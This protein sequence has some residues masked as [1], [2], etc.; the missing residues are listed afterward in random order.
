M[1]L[2]AGLFLFARLA[3]PS[4]Y[5]PRT[6]LLRLSSTS[7]NYVFLRFPEEDPGISRHKPVGFRTGV[8]IIARIRR[9][10]GV[11][12]GFRPRHE[13]RRRRCSDTRSARS[14]T[15][16]V[17]SRAIQC[18]RPL[19]VHEIAMLS[20]PLLLTIR[21]IQCVPA[22]EEK[23]RAPMRSFDYSRRAVN[24]R[25][26]WTHLSTAPRYSRSAST[27]SPPPACRNCEAVRSEWKME[28]LL[29]VDLTIRCP[30]A[31]L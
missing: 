31:R 9:R 22:D 16:V 10:N 14:F 24:E 7:G 6:A 11:T 19:V 23:L 27:P 26:S 20:L 5:I 4:E 29:R 1:R 13:N 3:R 30:R 18:E 21:A 15:G 25:V 17:H 2:P 12:R 28:T 8:E